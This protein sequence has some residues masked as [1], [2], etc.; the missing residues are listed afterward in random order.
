MLV[1]HLGGQV[2]RVGR[3]LDKINPLDAGPL[4]EALR[5]M[6]GPDAQALRWEVR[7]RRLSLLMALCTLIRGAPGSPT[8]RKSSSAAPST[9]SMTGSSR[10][11]PP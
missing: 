5:R 1:E 10:S 7:S 3:G 9:C 6:S 11:S 4:G 8:P 2:I